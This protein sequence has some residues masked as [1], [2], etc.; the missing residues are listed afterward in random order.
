MIATA[1]FILAESYEST[2]NDD[3]NPSQG[4]LFVW[5]VSMAF[6]LYMASILAGGS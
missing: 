1:A 5:V 6:D 3:Y 2:H 4:V